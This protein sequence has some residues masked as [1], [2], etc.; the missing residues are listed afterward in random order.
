[1]GTGEEG[2][3]VVNVDME[4]VEEAEKNYRVRADLAREEWHYEYRHQRKEKL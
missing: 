3:S 4:I 2:M 1:M